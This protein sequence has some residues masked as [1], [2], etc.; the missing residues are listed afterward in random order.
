[1]MVRRVSSPSG[2]L[3]QHSSRFCGKQEL[4][5]TVTRPEIPLRDQTD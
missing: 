3:G 1:M 5:V 4:V 2:V